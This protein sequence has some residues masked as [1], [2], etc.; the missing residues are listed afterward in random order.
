MVTVSQARHDVV[1]RAIADPTRRNI[2]R[3]LR[4][5]ERSVGE[6]AANF[7][8][9]RPAISK[10]HGSRWPISV[11]WWTWLRRARSVVTSAT[12]MLP[13]MLRATL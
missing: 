9:S 5:G 2:L 1:F 13:P 10:L 4:G 11:A 12:P 7:E 8:Q 3:L 6:I